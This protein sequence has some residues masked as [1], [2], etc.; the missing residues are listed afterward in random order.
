MALSFTQSNE[1]VNA[2]ANAVTALANSGKL[3][4]YSGTQPANADAGIGGATL[5]AEL[6]MNATAFAGAAAGVA[7]ANA[8][9]QDASADATGTAAWFR[10]WKSDG[11]SPLWDGS[12]G[13]SGCDLNL[14]TVSIVATATV[15]VSSMTFTLP[16]A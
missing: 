10:V 6:V 7:T 14:N 11:T 1:A 2:A 15:S 4:I 13:T 12:V 8:I 5:L 3:R 9:T 16:K